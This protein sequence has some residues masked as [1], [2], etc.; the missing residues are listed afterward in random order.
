MAA[1]GL[2]ERRAALWPYL[3]MPVAVLLV[4][5][6][7]NQLHERAGDGPRATATSAADVQP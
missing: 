3:V 1:S 6:T 5:Y 2:R 7:L 4:Y